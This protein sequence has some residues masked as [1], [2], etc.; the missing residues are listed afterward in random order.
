MRPKNSLVVCLVFAFG[1]LPPASA[2][3]INTYSSESL[4]AAETVMGFT[5]ASFTSP[6]ESPILTTSLSL[7]GATWSTTAPEDFEVTTQPGYY[8]SGYGLD[9]EI[10]PSSGQTLLQIAL[11]TGVTSFGLNVAALSSYPAFDA[12][13][14]TVNGTP[15]TILATAG[16]F[17][18]FGATFTS[19]IASFTVS[20][21]LGDQLIA[22]NLMFGTED[23]TSGSGGTGGGDPSP[24]PEAA[25][26]LMIGSG[27]IAMRLAGGRIHFLGE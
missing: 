27:L 12:A 14:I 9:L 8:P 3:L 20:V 2:T 18:F 16:A 26:L 25:S 5:N 19:P 1:V 21:P 6:T 10:F 4:W 13:T 23:D 24:T 7:L 17:P 15:L 11:P 22:G